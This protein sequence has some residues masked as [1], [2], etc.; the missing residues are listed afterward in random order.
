MSGPPAP[1]NDG[2]ELRV[3]FC[4]A[5]TSSAASRSPLG[6]P[7]TS[8][9]DNPLMGEES[10]S[11]RFP[12]SQREP[13]VRENIYRTTPRAEVQNAMDL[14]AKPREMEDVVD[15]SRRGRRRSIISTAVAQNA[16]EIRKSLSIFLGETCL[17]DMHVDP[18]A[19]VAE[20][21]IH[22]WNVD[23]GV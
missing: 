22:V 1:K 16:F 8:M 4:K 7:A 14:C 9:N 23:G 11:S 12:N 15:H 2:L 20:V 3:S 19:F 10:A 13:F 6:S 17:G 5:L 18:A 21:E